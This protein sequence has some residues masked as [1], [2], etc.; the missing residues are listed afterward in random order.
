MTATPS[1]GAAKRPR[2]ST[3]ARAVAAAL[4]LALAPAVALVGAPPPAAYSAAVADYPTW[5]EVK[6]AKQDEAAAKALRS[7][8]EGRL[9]AL[10]DEV[11]RT[12]AEA[13]KKGEEYYAA[14]Q[15]H[16]EQVIVTQNLR[17]QA[18]TAQA[19][20]DAAYS[21]AAVLIAQLS[22]TGG[23]D[24]TTRLFGASES[25]D[26][27][28]YQIQT[29]DLLS[30]RNSRLYEE[31][32]Q[33]QNTADSLAAQAAV[34]EEK[35]D[36]LRVI[37]EQ[38]LKEAQAAAQA[39]QEQYERTQVEIA[40]VRARVEYLAGVREQ[41]IADYNAGIAAQWGSG[42]GGELSATGWA[43]PSA[44][45]ISSQF[46]N[47]LHPIYGYWRLHTGVDLA[48]QGCG[49]PIRAAHLGTVVYAGWSGDLG[50]FIEIQHPGGIRTGYAHIAPGGIGVHIG[51]EVGSGQLI[52]KVGTTGGS[53]GCHL[54]FMVRVNGVLTDP[55]PFLRNQ[56]ISLG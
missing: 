41:M 30:G 32:T 43:R 33:L 16:D 51:Q 8:L 12:K 15:A 7:R 49:A 23:N 37:A 1:R 35:L 21:R 17:S 31:A 20:A 9:A 50:N 26:S 3:I 27:L 39:A 22:K 10:E 14:Q 54:H 25:P 44:G 47:R 52:A 48:G 2:R 24:V 18:A 5:D 45:Y 6:K 19:D 56:G 36:E 11:A 42:A 28:L 13:E 55:V 53:T 4:A 29:S 38:K 46:G 40:E 34:A